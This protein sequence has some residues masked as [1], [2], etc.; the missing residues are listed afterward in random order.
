MDLQGFWNLPVID[1]PE[2]G[3]QYYMNALENYNALERGRAALEGREPKLR[4]P[5]L[6]KR[7]AAFLKQNLERRKAE[8]EREWA[9]G[10]IDRMRPDIEGTAN[11]MNKLRAELAGPTPKA[12]S[13]KGIQAVNDWRSDKGVRLIAAEEEYSR[14]L[15]QWGSHQR[16]LTSARAASGYTERQ[17]MEVEARQK[18]TAAAALVDQAQQKLGSVVDS[19]EA[20]LAGDD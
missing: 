12:I 1:D 2:S 3:E 13:K 16:I 17:A 9:Q 15:V 4:K 6:K 5:S 20:F 14:L 8:K 18:L 10:V 11:L 7:S 19:G